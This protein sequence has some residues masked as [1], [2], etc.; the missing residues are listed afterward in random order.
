[1]LLGDA[2][3]EEAV[4]MRLAELRQTGRAGHGR[5]DG[6]DVVA[7]VAELHQ[8]LGEDRR[9]IAHGAR[10]R[11]AGDG[12]DD[13]GGVHE[14]GLIGLRR[15]EAAALVRLRMDDDGAAELARV[16]QGVLE[17]TDV[18]A[19]DGSH[20]LQAEV[21]EHL[22]RHD[23]RLQTLLGAVDD[24]REEIADRAEALQA[25]LPLAHDHVVGGLQRQGGEVFGQAA[26]RRR[27]AA[28]VV[29]DHDD[30]GAV[31]AGG[32]VVERLP[33]HAARQGA[34]ADDGDDVAVVLAADVEALGQ[35]VGRRQRGRRM[36][37]FGP[38]VGALRTA[39][40]AGQA[41]LLPQ[42]I[43]VAGAAGEHFVHVGL[44]SGVEDDRVRRRV[45]D[46]VQRHGQLHDAEVRAEV[47][48]G[49]GHLLHEELADFRC[50]IIE[51]LR[52]QRAHVGG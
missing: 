49:R 31:L 13:A 20:V 17:R 21:G 25:G 29:V 41:V 47:P 50:Q 14:V 36:R 6:G 23:R 1:M 38:V 45:E 33:A 15:G 18:V 34:V 32:D 5:G 46:A 8:F 10:F 7:L 16:A 26:D 37:G 48:T 35:A 11:L 44:V 24:A 40:V 22:V 27:V 9:P 12:V 4:G 19:V 52:A 2:D 39:R 3:V 51:L 43:E 30:H 42:R 28:A